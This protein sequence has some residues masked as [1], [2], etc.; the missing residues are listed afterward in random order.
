MAYTSFY[1]SYYSYG[2]GGQYRL[3]LDIETPPSSI[4]SGTSS[5]TLTANLYIQTLGPLSDSTNNNT[6]TGDLGSA[7]GAESVSHGSSGGTTKVQTKSLAVATVYGSTVK[8]DVAGA[9]SGYEALTNRSIS[10][11]VTIPKRAYTTPTAPSAVAVARVSDTQHTVTWTRSPSTA[12]PYTSQNVQRQTDGGSWVTLAAVSGT[13]TSYSDTGTVAGHKY[14]Y[15]VQAVNST[16]TSTSGATGAVFTTPKP[17]TSATAAKNAAG[18]IDVTWVNNTPYTE[19]ATE[20]WESQSGGAF[21]LLATVAAGVTTWTHA[22]PSAA[23]THTYEVRAKTTTGT[24]LYSAYA[25]TN[26][27]Q[28]A[29]AP[30]APSN[31]VP[32]GIAAAAGDANTFTWKHNPN[33]T[34]PQSAYEI[35]W[36]VVGASTWNTTGKI[37][38]SVSSRTWPAGT[39]T[40]GTTI[41]WQVRTYGASP[42]AS[43]W[44]ATATLIVSAKPTVAIL[45]PTEGEVLV[46]STGTVTWTYFDPEGT[47]QAGWETQ[48]VTGGTTVRTASGS[49]PQAAYTYNYTLADGA[50]YTMRVRVQDGAGLWSDWTEVHVTVDYLPPAFVHAEA[51]YDP[52]TGWVAINLHPEAPVPGVTAE[53]DTVDVERSIDGGP[54]V[55]IAEGIPADSSFVDTTASVNGVNCYRLTV[56]SVDGA[57]AIEDASRIT[58][59]FPTPDVPPG[60]IAPEDEATAALDCH[61]AYVP[62]YFTTPNGDGTYSLWRDCFLPVVTTETDNGYL[63]TG[64]AFENVVAIMCDLALSATVSRDKATYHFAGR[65][66]PVEYTSDYLN[67]VV[68]VAGTVTDGFAPVEELG[69]TDTIVLWRDPTGRRIFGSIGPLAD[70]NLGLIAPDAWN[71]SFAV[72]QV[73]YDG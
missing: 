67:R 49:G 43:P 11:S 32:N 64:A 8:V 25:V 18:G 39:F 37:T 7:S 34:S 9:I 33:D 35:Q 55:L 2:S 48:L 29:S 63:S 14:A 62:T 53:A 20:I 72:T 58:T 30:N 47:A 26:T 38:S 73:D 59:N 50:D 12:G 45:T 21:A 28:L 70:T 71:A 27:V 42:T 61:T 13:A 10:G 16:G 57:S 36:R 3:R 40:N 5:V 66:W 69:L 1:T 54:W 22:A 51:E 31:L 44:S 56:H 65:A 15:R 24:V 41:E 19:Y 68:N 6:I 52:D 46:S 4:S 23:V 60:Y 17:P